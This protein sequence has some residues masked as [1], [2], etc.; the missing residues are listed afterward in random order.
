MDL[1]KCINLFV[2]EI[3]IFCFFFFLNNYPYGSSI[4]FIYLFFFYQEAPFQTRHSEGNIK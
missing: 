2:I 1:E 4:L 3:F